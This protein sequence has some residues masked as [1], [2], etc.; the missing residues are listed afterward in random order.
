MA[1]CSYSD[2]HA[3]NA[4]VN[5]GDIHPAASAVSKVKPIDGVA[6]RLYESAELRCVPTAHGAELSWYRKDELLTEDNTKYSFSRDNSSLTIHNVGIDDLGVYQCEESDELRANVTLYSYPFVRDEKSINTAPGYSVTLECRARGLPLPVVTWY[7]NQN[8]IDQQILQDGKRF[9]FENTTVTNGQL[10]I[11]DL[12]FDDY[13]IYTCVATNPFGSNNG[14][15]L[16]RVKSQWNAL[17]P[18]IGIAVQLV[19]LA[20]IIFF[21]ERNKKK[22][23]EIE[24]KREAEFN[25]AHPVDSGRGEGARQRKSM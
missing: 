22:E 17:W 1:A 10:V 24:K 25:K 21:Y 14:T 20:V 18:I 4:T 9:V 12:H 6:R 11:S 13:T 23:M 7:N 5:G 3:S 2:T 8:G 15:T 16:L 19:I